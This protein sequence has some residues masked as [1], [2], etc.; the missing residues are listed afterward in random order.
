MYTIKKKQVENFKN[1]LDFKRSRKLYSY[2]NLSEL[3][4]NFICCN[5]LSLNPCF[6]IGT[7][8]EHLRVAETVLQNLKTRTMFLFT[9]IHSFIYSLRS[10]SYDRSIRGGPKNNENFFKSNIS[11]NI[12]KI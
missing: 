8:V 5:F 6:N 3:R 4:R 9:V 2:L 7:T 11:L 12:S 1:M 10:L